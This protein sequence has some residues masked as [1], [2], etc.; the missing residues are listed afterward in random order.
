MEKI[1]E[2]ALISAVLE[3]VKKSMKIDKRQVAEFL[4]SCAKKNNSFDDFIATL[5]TR[6]VNLP[7]DLSKYIFDVTKRHCNQVIPENTI[8]PIS[9]A[10]FDEPDIMQP[11]VGVIYKGRVTSVTNQCA[12]VKIE[13][14]HSKPVGMLPVTEMSNDPGSRLLA[15]DIVGVGQHL[16]VKVIKS[17]TASLTLSIKG[18][19]QTTGLSYEEEAV[20]ENTAPTG[21]FRTMRL[22][23]PERFEVEQLMR[24]GTVTQND[25]HDLAGDYEQ[26][27]YSSIPETYFE[28]A[29]NKTV[30][31]FL[32]GLKTDKR[33]IEPL[34]V[35]SNPEGSL[36]RSAREASRLSREKQETKRS[37][38]G[39]SKSIVGLLDDEAPSVIPTIPLSELPEWKRQTFGSFGPTLEKK[40]LP[41]SDY[42]SQIIDML[43]KNRVFILVGETGCGKTTQIPQ[44]LLRSG[45]A[46]DLMIGVTQ[47][48]RVAA[49]SVAK[50]VADETNSIIG[51]LIGYQVRFEE[52]TSRNTK[53]KFMTDGMLLKEC[54]GDRQLSNYGVIML[55]EAHER[56][57]HTDVLFGLMKELLSKDDRLKVIVTSATLQ[58]EKF[59]SF[60]F[61]CPVLEVPGRTFPVT[62]SFAVTAFTDYLQASVNTVLKLHQTEEKPGDILLFLTGQDDIDTACEQIYQ[63]SKPIE[64]NF[65]KLIVLPIYSSL[66]TEQQ[67]MIFQP[68]PPGQRKVVVATNIAETSITIDG[69]RYVVD[70]GLVKEMRYDPRT[71]MD[72]LEVVPISKAA[73][74]QRKGRAGRT[75]AGKCIRLYTEDSYNNEMKETTIPE[76]QRSNMAMV[77]LDMKVIGIDD[78]IGFDFM[79]KP[80]TKIIID[81]LDQLYTLGALDEEG[82]LTPLGRDM[83]KFSLNPQL[84][85]MLIMSSMLGCSEEVLVLVAILS[86]QGIWYRPRKKQA[87]ADAMKARLNRDEGDHMT[88]LHVFREW[89]KNGEREAWCKENYVHYRSLKR[90]KD[91]MTQLRQ[92]M[93]QFHV[94]LVSCGKEIIPIL[95]AIVSGFFAKAARRYMGTEYKTIV[96]DH[97]VYIFP[98]SA[99]F[100][101]EPEYC[102]FHELVNTTREYM[103]NTVAVDPR[104]LV[105]LAPA[106]YRKAS[107]LEMTSRKRADRVNPLAD[108]KSDNKDRKWRITE[109]RI[110]RI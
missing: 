101:R 49:I 24:A 110:I 40:K 70:P 67:T 73:A 31:P 20:I 16:F 32:Q 92:Q 100:G 106:F 62:T 1:R 30:P 85:K 61:N 99:L 59:S 15:T 23:S 8:V 17:M 37:T 109:Q 66:P 57:I 47:P 22:S 74:N 7:I 60:F 26:I 38:Q 4:I 45:I 3:A 28:I 104:W 105:E 39:S 41:I 63:R 64:E 78:L 6:K 102:V 93:E 91:V 68:T 80:P 43:S 46:G 14:F 107:P 34:Y 12:F 76:I 96:D 94:P 54:L 48:R 19:D 44:F 71:G 103:R 98:G 2:L 42:E 55:D 97:P 87:E 25:L 89:Q 21:A 58:K 11:E 84:A 9:K 88:L 65:G 35:E 52:K 79:D 51:D 86:V 33:K 72:T 69:I 5:K 53:V 83:S 82:N 77:A 108:R 10:S 81:A 56:T 50:R 95:K 75:A 13:G 90:A 29:L 27:S 36:A 18:I